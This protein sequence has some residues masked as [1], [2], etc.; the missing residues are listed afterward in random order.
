[1]IISTDC[2]LAQL[3]DLLRTRS[4]DHPDVVRF[5]MT[6]DDNAD[7]RARIER[8]RQSCPPQGLMLCLRVA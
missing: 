3:F 4:L 6:H 8:A 5:L 7:F 2:L 1:M